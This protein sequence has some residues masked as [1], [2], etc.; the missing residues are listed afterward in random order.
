MSLVLQPIIDKIEK[1][2]NGPG[3]LAQTPAGE[4]N[5]KAVLLAGVFDLP[6]KAAV[7]NTVQFNGHY[8][9]TYCK[10]KG[11]H[12]NHRHIYP[13]T[14][15]H[16]LRK[17]TEMTQWAL[18]AER[19]G[20]PVFGVK[21]SSILSGV[22]NIPYGIP[23]DYM[24]A[25]LE[26]VVKTL[27]KCWFNQENHGR[28]YYLKPYISHI[29]QEMLTIKP[30]HELPRRPRSIESS[31]LYWKASEYRAFMLFYAIPILRKY[32]QAE[33]VYHLSLL[34]FSMNKLLSNSICT[35][36]LPQ[37]QTQLELFYDLI[38]ELYG[39]GVCTANVHSIIHL[40]RFVRLW[41]P[42]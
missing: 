4:K 35:Y 41:G 13:P 24:H 33:Y 17:E 1:L 36:D 6:A 37:V 34:V 39:V 21:G 14:D 28:P 2:Q 10:D 3:L 22:I 27:L 9:C 29:D 12:F 8:G 19:L 16:Q 31:L 18:E 40:T 15:S 5:V 26:G 23:I 20:K 7:L 38:P 25:V 30:P 42:L 32:L 11:S